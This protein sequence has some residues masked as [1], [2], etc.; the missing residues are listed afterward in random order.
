MHAAPAARIERAGTRAASHHLSTAFLRTRR[1]LVGIRL[2]VSRGHKQTNNGRF[3]GT[4][5][6]SCSLFS[7]SNLCCELF[8]IP[9]ESDLAWTVVVSRMFASPLHAW[10]SLHR[11][12]GRTRVHAPSRFFTSL[13][14]EVLLL[15]PACA[16]ATSRFQSSCDCFNI[17]ACCACS[18]ASCAMRQLVRPARDDV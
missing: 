16:A 1:Q 3:C 17:S 13:C 6:S 5:P 15:F 2:S 4:Y 18:A 9:S 8:C 10:R 12:D 14:I 7:S 11:V